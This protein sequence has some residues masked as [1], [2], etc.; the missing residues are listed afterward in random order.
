[1]AL[2]IEALHIPFGMTIATVT[3]IAVKICI[4]CSVVSRRAAAGMPAW[5]FFTGTHLR[6]AR[7]RH[8]EPPAAEADRYG[9]R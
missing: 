7:Q 9:A 2:Y 5:E 3:A 6:D 1:M 4:V 8:P